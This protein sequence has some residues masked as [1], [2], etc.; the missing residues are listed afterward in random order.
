MDAA[1]QSL[2]AAPPTVAHYGDR[3]YWDARYHSQPA[4]FD[5]YNSFWAIKGILQS[6]R[7]PK[8]G[9]ILHVGVGLST[10]QD[11]MRREG[12]TDI[13]CIDFSPVCIH[14]LQ[15]LVPKSS[16][17]TVKYIVA[18]IRNLDHADF[19]NT[20]FAVVIDKGTI[21]S[22]LCGGSF[23][24]IQDAISEISR[25]LA[26]DGVFICVT[27]GS[28]RMRLRYFENDDYNWS[29]QIYTTEKIRVEDINTM[30]ANSLQAKW[31]G[32]YSDQADLRA[33]DLADCYFVYVCQK[34]ETH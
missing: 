26:A 23:Q 34:C 8:D 25:T 5:W 30:I 33:L 20:S 29:I 22:I 18:D 28:P 9:P 31:H 12:Y 1:S 13:T 17:G 21:D 10:L 16:A 7:L 14:K 2:V 3:N 6:L 11:D 27:Y 24:G 4:R 19:P 15:Q 32:P